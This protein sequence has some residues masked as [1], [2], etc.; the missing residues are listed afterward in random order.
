MLGEQLQHDAE[1]YPGER[2]AEAEV[3]A[4]AERQ[5]PRGV[6][7]VDVEGVRIGEPRRVVLVV[8]LVVVS[9]PAK[10]NP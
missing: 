1:L 2:R 9:W 3:D 7:A 8:R 10:L 5:V 6:G 4:L